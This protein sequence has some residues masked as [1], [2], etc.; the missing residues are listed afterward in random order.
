MKPAFLLILVAVLTS[1]TPAWSQSDDGAGSSAHH[2][3]FHRFF[4]AA[5]QDMKA[6]AMA[7]LGNPDLPPSYA[8]DPDWPANFYRESRKK[9]SIYWPDGSTSKMIPRPDGGFNITG[10]GGMTNLIPAGPGRYAV[11]GPEGQQSVAAR[12][13]NGSYTITGADGRISLAVPLNSGGYSIRYSNGKVATV[14]AG[15][16][17]SKHVFTR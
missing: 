6:T 9:V 13:P 16:G 14:V 1:L 17:G 15:P 3:F 2:R 11:F 12:N 7:V 8:S 4:R 5:G 10:P